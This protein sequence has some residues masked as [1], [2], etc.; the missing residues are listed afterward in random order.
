MEVNGTHQFTV[1]TVYADNIHLLGDHIN[2]T[3]NDAKTPLEAIRRV[4]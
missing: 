3:K 2:T 1:L 4:G